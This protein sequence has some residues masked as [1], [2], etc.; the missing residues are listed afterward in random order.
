MHACWLEGSEPLAEPWLAELAIDER[1][2]RSHT[3]LDILEHQAVAMRP[4]HDAKMGA[5]LM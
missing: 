4:E 5:H 2:F 3:L 1:C